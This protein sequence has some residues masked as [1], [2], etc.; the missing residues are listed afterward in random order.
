LVL[1][2]ARE[3]SGR[4][5]RDEIVIIRWRDIPA[6]VNGRRGDERHQVVLPRRFQRSIDEAAMRAGKK[7]ANEYIAEWRRETR[8]LGPGVDVRATVDA[9]ATGFDAALSREELQRY[10]AAEGWDPD[11]SRERSDG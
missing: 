3:R 4:A 2:S 10:V 9:I 7:S 11:R 1:V 6:Q 8:T 5:R